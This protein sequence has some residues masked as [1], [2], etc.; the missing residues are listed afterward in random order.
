MCLISSTSI[1]IQKVG[2]LGA[3]IN[4]CHAGKPADALGL[5]WGRPGCPGGAQT[6]SKPICCVV[7]PNSNIYIIYYIIYILLFYMS[8]MHIYGPKYRSSRLPHQKKKLNPGPK[9]RMKNL[10]LWTMTMSPSLRM[11]TWLKDMQLVPKWS[12]KM[13][14]L[15]GMPKLSQNIH[16]S[17]LIFVVIWS[18]LGK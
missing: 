7:G 13:W 2:Y 11:F 6:R 18:E 15:K 9:A 16:T 10:W 5:W 12:L 1:I 8:I 4:M 17:F 14:W 3:L